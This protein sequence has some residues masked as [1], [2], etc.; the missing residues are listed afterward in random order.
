MKATLCSVSMT[1]VPLPRSNIHQSVIRV[2]I[3]Q[4]TCEF[5]RSRLCVCEVKRFPHES[6]KHVKKPLGA[7]Q[8]PANTCRN[9]HARLSTRVLH[10]CSVVCIYSL[11]TRM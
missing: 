4:S 1:L 10:S 6:G 11:S 2:Q 3:R 8:N 9:A 7:R 5:W